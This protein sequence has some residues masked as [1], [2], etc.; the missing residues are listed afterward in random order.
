V[1][2]LICCRLA[3]LTTVQAHPNAESLCVKLLEL[4]KNYD[5]IKQEQF[6]FTRKVF[7]MENWKEAWLK[8][9]KN[10]GPSGILMGQQMR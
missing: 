9:I 2:F 7:N 3:D 10:Y 1:L 5:Q 4:L 8:I 6:E